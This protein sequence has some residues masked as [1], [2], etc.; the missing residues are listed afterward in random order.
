MG[1]YDYLKK[2]I[3]NSAEKHPRNSFSRVVSIKDIEKAEDSLGFELTLALKEFWLEIGSGCINK[4]ING[5]DA[6]YYANQ[7]LTPSE[8]ADIILLRE[9]S[10]Y[11]L[12]EYAVL[13]EE[14]DIPFFEIGDSSDFMFMKRF[15]ENKEAIYDPM[16]RIVAETFEQF[17]K[18]LYYESP[19]FYLDIGAK[20]DSAE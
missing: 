14:G 18:K 4:A 19:T 3:N 13:M 5:A 15:A 17:I 6:Y 2:Y 8:V 1:K 11:M 9:D 12:P 20:K 16:G 10:G 7:I